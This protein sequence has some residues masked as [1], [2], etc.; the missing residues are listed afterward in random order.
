MIFFAFV[1]FIASPAMGVV[2]YAVIDNRGSC[3]H[4]TVRGRQTGMRSLTFEA[5]I[6]S[7]RYTLSVIGSAISISARLWILQTCRCDGLWL[8]I[9]P[10]LAVGELTRQRD[11]GSWTI[12]FLA[13]PPSTALVPSHSKHDG[14]AS[15]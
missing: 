7:S 6:W 14:V 4:H 12:C 1:A 15:S 8:S 5:L 11:A 10:A 3:L 2:A 13:P 9:D